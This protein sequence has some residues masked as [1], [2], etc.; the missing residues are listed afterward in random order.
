MPGTDLQDWPVGTTTT[1]TTSSEHPPSY[2]DI[3]EVLRKTLGYPV[4]AISAP[5]QAWFWTEEWQ[6]REAEAD[7]DLAAGRGVIAESAEELFRLFD[8]DDEDDE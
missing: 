4:E 8:E 5:D 1:A 7:A 3:L 6:E 2:G